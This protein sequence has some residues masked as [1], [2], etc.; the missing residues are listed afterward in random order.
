MALRD[1]ENEVSV[2]QSLAPAAR[3]ASANGTSV[4]LQGYHSAMVVFNFG[5]WTDG[6]HT[7]SLEHSTNN[8]TFVACDSNSLNGSFVAVSGSG[9]SNT[10]QKIGYTGGYRYIRAVLTVSGATTGALANAVVLRSDA[11][12]QPV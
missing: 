4:D 9:G 8:S 7:P 11:A 5:A 3:T 10:I 12:V 1:I 2:A 6:S